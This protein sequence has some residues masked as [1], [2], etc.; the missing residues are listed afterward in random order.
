[1]VKR[2]L[3]TKISGKK[4]R[5]SMHAKSPSAKTKVMSRNEPM[6]SANPM[7]NTLR[8]AIAKTKK[9]IKLMRLSRIM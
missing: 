7:R 8:M 4:T 6:A 2:I 9:S 5:A 3:V 1:M